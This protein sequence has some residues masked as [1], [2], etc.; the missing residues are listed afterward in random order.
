[1]TITVITIGLLIFIG[2]IFWTQSKRSKINPATQQKFQKHW[3]AILKSDPKTAILDADKLLD[4]ALKL[5]GYT[6][7]LG[8]KMKKAGQLFSDRN[9]IWS[10]HKLRNRIAHELDVKVSEKETRTALTQFKKA[11]RD[12]GIKL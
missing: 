10:A 8:E 6:G 4:Q 7:T 5:K 12:L 1:M 9:G 11:L 2:L 3:H